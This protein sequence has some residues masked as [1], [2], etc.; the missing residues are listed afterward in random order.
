M[1]F[2]QKYRDTLARYV[3]LFMNELQEDEDGPNLEFGALEGEVEW[4]TQFSFNRL[5]RLFVLSMMNNDDERYVI[6]TRQSPIAALKYVGLLEY[7]EDCAFNADNGETVPFSDS[8]DLMAI[9]KKF[10]LSEV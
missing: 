4:H 5:S 8:D 6:I 9:I 2:T 3:P 7:H 10:R 1:T